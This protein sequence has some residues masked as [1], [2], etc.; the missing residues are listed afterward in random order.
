M[1]MPRSIDIQ[2]EMQATDW[3]F[4]IGVN[5]E[6][7]KKF[8]LKRALL[9]AICCLMTFC[10]S[11]MLSVEENLIKSCFLRFTPEAL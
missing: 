4:E 5:E 8:T 9:V 11:C 3:V 1:N 10:T 6:K 7:F 2:Q